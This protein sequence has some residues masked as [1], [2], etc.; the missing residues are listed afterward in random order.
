[1]HLMIKLYITLTDLKR[2]VNA[3]VRVSKRKVKVTN[4]FGEYACVASSLELT[5]GAVSSLIDRLENRSLVTRVRDPS[6]RRVVLIAPTKKLFQTVG[7]VYRRVAEE[8]LEMAERYGDR[9]TK[10]AI[11][12]L[13][14]VAVA[15]DTATARAND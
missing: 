5:T 13:G 4:L 8:L 1:L 7:P 10:S 12:V 11:R 2:L 6:D 15:Y 9:K 3:V 14:D